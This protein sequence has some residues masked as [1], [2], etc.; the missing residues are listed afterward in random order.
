M[1]EKTLGM[2]KPDAVEKNA[3][4]EII[5]MIENKNIKIKAVKMTRLT[6]KSA[7]EFYFVHKG[8]PFF[9]DLV[10][11]MISGPVIPMILEGENVIIEYRNLMGST[12]FTKAEEG[13]IRKKFGS[14]MEKNAVHG[15]DSPENAQK[16]ISFF[17]SA[18]EELLIF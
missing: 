7:E 5:S 6:K 14:A 11:F 9:N 12:N 18:H 16:E 4:G 3:I 17:F 1:T 13:T 10:K 8:R 15:S 2:I